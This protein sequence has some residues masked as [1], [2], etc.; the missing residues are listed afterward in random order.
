MTELLNRIFIKNKEN[1]SDPLVRKAYGTVSS[2][3]GII[4]NF[5]L[6][7]IKLLAGL[8]SGSLA[9]T[10]DAFNNLSDAG[11]SFI[12][13]VSFKIS[14]K[15]A[16]R[17]HPFGHARMEYVSSM[18][19]SFLI[20]LVGFELLIDSVKSLIDPSSY[21]KSELKLITIIILSV[22]I[23]MKLWL[24]FFY[25]KNGKKIQSEALKASSADSFS[26]TVS[27]TAVLAS[28]I[29][30]SIT[31]LYQ[32]DS[33]V[34]IIV[35]ILIIIAGAKILN[36]TKN[37]LLGEAPVDDI[38]EDINKIV[39]EYPDIIGLHDLMVHNYGPKTYFAS[40]HAEVDGEKNIFGLHDMIDNVERRIKD[41]LGIPCTIHLDPIVTN[42]ET[43][44]ELRCFTCDTVA[45]LG[46]NCTVHDFRVVIGETHTNLIFD[47]ALPFECKC[48]EREVIQRI[49]DEIAKKRKNHFC[50]ITVDR[51]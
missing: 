9:I 32:I 36:E 11:S 45:G 37:A 30:V 26:D 20:L 16:D 15:P 12:T 51:T 13:L 25:R 23:L 28:S 10:A 48:S 8:L 34:G 3:I 5:I 21:Q 41:E 42:D 14:S 19:V 38:I 40:F 50:V 27:T 39:E 22:S 1:T 44:N 7:A 49:N 4:V 31:D 33:I 35:S 18:I 17:D 43:V 47:V 24:G 2:I 46:F 29:I 6:A